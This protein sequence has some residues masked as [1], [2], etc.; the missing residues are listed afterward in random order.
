MVKGHLES[1]DTCIPNLV[2]G[3]AS[4]LET[5]PP[6][7]SSCSIFKVP[8][9]LRNIN[10]QAYTPRV[11]SI[12]PIHLGKPNLET[13]QRHKW[14]YFKRFLQRSKQG[15][16]LDNY[17][18]AIKGCELR[19]RQSYAET[20]YLDSDQFVEM[21]L[22]DAAFCIELFW[23]DHFPELIDF[24]YD[25]IY[26][27]PWIKN[28]LRRDMALLENQIPFFVIQ[29]L[30]ELAELVSPHQGDAPSLLD[31]TLGFFKERSNAVSQ[32]A[33]DYGIRHILDILRYCYLPSNLEKQFKNIRKIE[34]AVSAT[35]LHEAGVEFRI[36]KTSSMLEIHF[37]LANGVLEIPLI[38]L[39]DKTE[40]LFRNLVALEQC[41]YRHC[42]YIS[43]YM[44]FMD[45]L[46][47]TSEDVDLL[48]Q[49]NIIEN[50]LG[51]SSRGAAL[52]NNLCKETIW[53]RKNFYY[54][55]LCED[56]T[57]YCRIPW[58]KWKATL[59]R[60]YFSTPWMVI[61]VIAA[62]VLL[63]L[64]FIHKQQ[65][66]PSVVSF[67]EDYAGGF[68]HIKLAVV[69]V[70][71]VVERSCWKSR[72]KFSGVASTTVLGLIV[73]AEIAIEEQKKMDHISIIIED[74]H[75]PLAASIRGMLERLPPISPNCSI[76]RVPKKLRN[77]NEKA[78][79]P[80]LV[81]IGPLHHGQKCLQAMEEV[82]LRYLQSFLN[83]TSLSLENFVKAMTA[84]EA[85]AR[86]CYAESIGF[87][88]DEFVTMMLVDASFIIETILMYNSPLSEDGNNHVHFRRRTVAD[89][90]SDMILLENQLPFFILEGLFDLAL[91]S[92]GQG[93]PSLLD[94]SLY[95]FQG[96]MIMNN[97]SRTMN[98]TFEVKHFVDLLRTCHLPS[99]QRSSSGYMANYAVVR[100]ATELHEAGVNFKKGSRNRLLDV[101]YASGQ[102]QIPPFRIHDATEI[103]L[104]NLIAL[105]LCHYQLDSY[106]IDY[107]YFMGNLITTPKDVD[108]LIKNGVI[109]NWLRDDDATATLFNNLPTEVSLFTTNFYYFGLSEELNAFCKVPWHRWK[110]TLKRDYFST[111]WKVASTIAAVIFLLLTFTQTV[112]SII[113]LQ[114]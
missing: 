46:I 9:R 17:V 90:R 11:V 50:W 14:W 75:I 32:F 84:W 68:G 74:P 56:L 40:S 26:Y 42:S 57:A 41:L 49:N 88:S 111:P 82:K 94:L 110:V 105:E 58:H 67:I 16:S 112:C 13:M 27:R 33:L 6:F 85:R 86:N 80:Q 92:H 3:I 97:V 106:I 100:N 19:A 93:N 20:I 72:V 23:M 55:H 2:T 61:S 69:F 89:L 113:S 109:E 63:V 5:L 77:T 10:E 76:Y 66:E 60:D 21:L 30:F 51:D 47:N 83:R 59:K 35:E 25:G 64:T 71:F 15:I 81:S 43:D 54:S 24:S 28:D 104:R 7:Y 45:C 96:F 53:W 103:V 39:K 4:K 95:Y 48:I 79:T 108:L 36:G 65:S 62:V 99:S 102:L 22:V 29:R 44:A 101:C 34:F 73:E 8:E 98:S 37:D 31:I 107:I 18:I 91:A 70:F 87:S 114:V 12:G 78:Y 38:K 1:P 52:F